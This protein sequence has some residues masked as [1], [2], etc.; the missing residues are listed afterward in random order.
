MRVFLIII[1]I[2]CVI[3][4]ATL[5][6]IFVDCRVISSCVFSQI[7]DADIFAE[8]IKSSQATRP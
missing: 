1:I 7:S 6:V 5:H 2:I 8:D 4:V 3:L